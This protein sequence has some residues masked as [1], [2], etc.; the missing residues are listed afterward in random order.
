MDAL[1]QVLGKALV[2]G[3]IAAVKAGK[4]RREALQE[5]INSLERDDVVSDEIYELLSQYANETKDF[6]E[7]GL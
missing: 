4:S 3:L 7:G 2:E 6:E 5:A 1:A